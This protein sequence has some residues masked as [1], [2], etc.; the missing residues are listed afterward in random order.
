MAG[1]VPES[2][3]LK[4]KHPPMSQCE[5]CQKP[6]DQFRGKRRCPTC[7]VPSLICKSCWQAHEDGSKTIDKSIRC[8]LCVEQ[9]I[10]S[11]RD[12]RQ[13]EQR[14]IQEYESKLASK[15]LLQAAAAPNPN[16]V[17]R[18]YLKNMCKKNMTED[19]LMEH[20]PGITHIVWR[21]VDRNKSN[22][23]VGKFNGQGWVEMESP[24]AAAR[25]VYK[26]GEMKIFGRPLY[27]EYQ[28]PG[29]KDVWPPPSSA[30]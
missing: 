4:Q 10:Q 11:K 12:L 3:E 18:L 22:N 17:T 14:E 21:M 19:V 8:D 15:G 30:V 26:S 27:I 23:G 20:V 29:G 16:K 1:D 5:S 25:A 13:K 24:D 6:W 28:P 9:N 2:F 7:G